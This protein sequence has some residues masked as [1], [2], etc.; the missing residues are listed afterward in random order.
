MKEIVNKGFYIQSLSF[1]YEIT[2]FNI[3]E[4]MKFYTHRLFIKN[5]PKKELHPTKSYQCLIW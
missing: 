1:K 4:F 2:I 3:Q 5:L